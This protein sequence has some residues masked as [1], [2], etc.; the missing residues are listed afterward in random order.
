MVGDDG[1]AGDEAAVR[2]PLGLGGAVGERFAFVE[3]ELSYLFEHDEDGDG[4]M[5]LAELEANVLNVGHS[6]HH[7]EF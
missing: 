2:P 5:T 7:D 4:F 1:G 3:A 6:L